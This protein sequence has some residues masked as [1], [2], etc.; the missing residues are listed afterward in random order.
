[1]PNAILRRVCFRPNTWHIKMHDLRTFSLCGVKTFTYL[2]EESSDSSMTD[3]KLVKLSF[4]LEDEG[5][6]VHVNFL[7]YFPMQKLLR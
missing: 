5:H 7:A 3:K 4:D 6:V 1:M 2:Q